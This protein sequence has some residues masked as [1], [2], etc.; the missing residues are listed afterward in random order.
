VQDCSGHGTCNPLDGTCTCATNFYGVDAYSCSL[1]RCPTNATGASC[2]GHGTCNSAT[3]LCTCRVGWSLA[4]CSRAGCPVAASASCPGGLAGAACECAGRGACSA[5]VCTCGAGYIGAA[6]QL[7]GCPEAYGAQCANQGACD[8]ETGLCSCADTFDAQANPIFFTD[9]DCATQESGVR[10][11][12]SLNFTGEL[13]PST[14]GSATAFQPFLGTLSP[15]A[16]QYFQFEVPSTQYAITLTLTMLVTLPGPPP[17]LTA[18]YASQ[19]RPTASAYTFL[20]IAPP[21]APVAGRTPV[22]I[23]FVAGS[24]TYTSPFSRTGTMLVTIGMVD[25]SSVSPVAF[26]LSLVRDACATLKC[27]FGSCVA[28]RC[29]CSRAN[30]AFM[31]SS[32]YGWSGTLC[33]QPDCPG[34]PDCNGARGTCLVPANAFN[35]SG[36]PQRG[37]LPRCVCAA[38]FSGD[39]CGQ[40][41]LGSSARAIA[42]TLTPDLAYFNAVAKR[43]SYVSASGL[44]VE[45]AILGNGLAGASATL[46]FVNGSYRGNLDAG[47]GGVRVAVDPTLL[48]AN[49]WS[50]LLSASTGDIAL[51]ARLDF[52]GTPAA[53]GVLLSQVNTA[54][55]LQSYRD[56]DV[57]QWR[58]AASV[59]EIS[60][61]VPSRPSGAVT[62]LGVFNGLYA[63][64]A[65]G[66]TL[67]VELSPT[68]PPALANCGGP[69]QGACVNGICVCALGFEGIRCDTAVAVLAAGVQAATP[70]L[71]PGEWSYFI[72]SPASSTLEV[73]LTLESATGA[74]SSASAPLMAAAWDSGR[75]AA[76]SLARISS[77][78]VFQDF[79]SISVGNASQ[80]IVARR[81]SPGSQAFLY[82]GVRNSPSARAA[83]AGLVTVSEAPSTSLAN[84]SAADA[85]AGGGGG[86]GGARSAAAVAAFCRAARCHGRGTFALINDAPS[87]VCEYGWNAD[88]ACLSPIFA[89]FSNV[90]AAAQ[91]VSSLCSICATTSPYARDQMAF[92]RIAQPLLKSTGLLLTLQPVAAGGAGGV[93]VGVPSLLVSPSL[94]R[95]ILDFSLVSA[96]TGANRS[97]LLTAASATGSYWA[98]VYANTP[99]AFRLAASRAKVP[100]PVKA[101]SSS[102]REFIDFVLSSAAAKVVL[103][104]GGGLLLMMLLGCV[105][106]CCCS[107]SASMGRLRARF[108]EVEEEHERQEALRRKSM[109]KL[110]AS[111]SASALA[112]TPAL[113]VALQR[114]TSRYGG[115]G[116]GAAAGAAAASPNRFAA[117]ADPLNAPNPL[118]ARR[119]PPAATSSLLAASMLG[120][121]VSTRDGLAHLSGDN[122]ARED[123]AATRQ[124]VVAAQPAGNRFAGIAS[125][126]LARQAAQQEQPAADEDPLRTQMRAI[127]AARAR[128]AAA[129]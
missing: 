121:N 28:G 115:A 58:A 92:F 21:S 83:F 26:S 91:N 108:A 97:M 56:F 85:G 101:V 18:A 32:T 25:A 70:T 39:A 105:A 111:L 7:T 50:G 45:F 128:A 129:M 67:Y 95:S 41:S 36:V 65:L 117:P 33:D 114:H 9:A 103:G 27:A 13:D 53:D 90:L 11:V 57:R 20:G 60:T 12:P 62:F 116:A 118:V 16:L 61:T 98:A 72:F 52:S 110:A 80:R 81:S 122:W 8:S 104:V 59:Q 64:A 6:C 47:G 79:D 94:P 63:K 69:A 73:V 55:T 46:P 74:S 102:L 127:K 2:S 5:G 93:A 119:P 71:A 99:G 40:Y 88:T 1:Q 96:S 3:G 89:S 109:S 76:T 84:C 124:R 75:Y 38:A 66:Y 68:C 54:P 120:G 100:V 34:T 31:F 49:G 10:P 19:G 82:V 51:Y 23:T 123:P 4:D 112:Q 22:A 48:V 17:I 15:K 42:S 107:K 43:Y 24:S 35:G 126:D 113:Q 78:A 125:A 87:C 86:G 37:V 106:D 29:Q 44:D 14:N 77:E 30:E